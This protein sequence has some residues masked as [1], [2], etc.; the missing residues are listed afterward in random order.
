MAKNKKGNKKATKASKAEDD[1]AESKILKPVSTTSPAKVTLSVKKGSLS[2]SWDVMKSVEDLMTKCRGE[3]CTRHAICV[4]VSDLA[5]EDEWPVCAEC[6]DTIKSGTQETS[7]TSKIEIAKEEEQEP[8]N[9]STPTNNDAQS[10]EEEDVQCG[11]TEAG[12]EKESVYAENQIKDPSGFDTP[13]KSNIDLQADDLN[14]DKDVEPSS[15]SLD[16]VEQDTSEDN[17]AANDAQKAAENR[18]PDSAGESEDE[19]QWELLK[20]FSIEE[21]TGSTP[22]FCDGEKCKRKPAVLYKDLSSS[23][24]WSS[25]L[26]CQV[27]SALCKYYMCRANLCSILNSSIFTHRR[28]NSEDGQKNRTKFPSKA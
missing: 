1:P 21:I 8:T 11:E 12:A 13:I 17:A 3:E 16:G 15:D 19:E 6:R 22:H 4:L 24:E 26:D 28:L 14:E 9:R 5:P 23:E 27:S 25:C 10:A 7:N 20:I 18:S 2:T